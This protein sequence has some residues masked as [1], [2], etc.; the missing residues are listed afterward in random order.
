MKT[1]YTLDIK[2]KND[3]TRN[4]L[5]GAEFLALLDSISASRVW[6]TLF[7]AP[8]LQTKYL[9]WSRYYRAASA[10]QARRPKR[11]ILKRLGAKRFFIALA[12]PRYRRHHTMST[13]P[14]ESIN[15][16]AITHNARCAV[17]DCGFGSALGRSSQ[18]F[19]CE[20]G[21]FLIFVRLSSL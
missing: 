10:G 8:S 13:L 1:C 20:I 19:S 18:T 11:G 9:Y 4:L 5:A 15:T 17:A 7:G 2:H 6:C 3:D 16:C 14:R 21:W 12:S